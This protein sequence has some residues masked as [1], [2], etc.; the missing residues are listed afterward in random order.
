[1][2]DCLNVKGKKKGSGQ[3]SGSNVDAPKN[4]LF[5]ALYSRSERETSPNVVTDV[6]Q[7]FSLNAYALLDLGATL[8]FVTP[9][10]ARNFYI[11]PDILNKTFR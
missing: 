5:Y 8:S 11:L 2:R 4:N 10:V 7:V 3:E 1:M 6:L 9:L